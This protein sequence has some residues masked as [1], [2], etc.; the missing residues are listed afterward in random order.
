[1]S[2]P[3]MAEEITTLSGHIAAATCRLLEVLAAFDTAGGWHGGGV[4]S[5]AQWL[6][7][8][9]GMSLS[10]AHEHLRV[11]HAL[12][13]LP[14][15]RA[16]FGRGELS[17]SKVRAVTRVADSDSEAELVDVATH[18][19]A[20]QLDRLCQGLARARSGGEV[21][22]QTARARFSA[23]WQ[24]DGML[25]ASG[26][27]DPEDGRLLLA[28]LAEQ[29]DPVVVDP[30]DDGV[31]H[32]KAQANGAPADGVRADLPGDRYR[33]AA[34]LAARSDA[35]ALV[36]LARQ[37]LADPPAHVGGSAPVRLV[38]HTTDQSLAAVTAPLSGNEPPTPL[39]Q[40]EVPAAPSPAEESSA[41][42]SPAEDTGGCADQTP[43]VGVLDSGPVLP[44]LPLGPDTLRRLA[45]EA[46]VEPATHPDDD[47]PGTVQ[48]RF[49]TA[50]QRRALLARDGGCAFPACSRRRHLHAHHRQRWSDGGS[51]TLGNLVLTCSHHH[52]LIH[53]GGWQLRRET[54]TAGHARWVAIG[55]DGQRRIAAPPTAGNAPSLPGTHNATIA[56]DTVTGHWRGEALHLDYAVSVMNQRT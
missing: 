13:D 21:L 17:Y 22:E 55:P 33:D 46:L 3:A 5:C 36:C 26:L 1:M 34:A 32:D 51:T 11:A 43:T 42:L 6:T 2:V 41:R 12:T 20:S 47:R 49:A 53:E 45:C 4:R 39:S 27:L 29:H 16:A 28:A 40:T 30:H 10:T 24:P 48:H 7:W 15:T 50:R 19:T 18:A 8:R 44:L 35:A 25:R 14:A 37:A 52:R 54:D 56:A 38:V 23:S 9:C 31:S